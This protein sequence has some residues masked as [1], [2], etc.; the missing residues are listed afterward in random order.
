[1]TFDLT[2]VAIFGPIFALILGFTLGA[3]FGVTLGFA[4]SFSGLATMALVTAA[5]WLIKD[6]FWTDI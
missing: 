6:F 2:V 1:L 5:R 4:N 3:T